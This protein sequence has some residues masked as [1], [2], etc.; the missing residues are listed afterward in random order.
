MTRHY[1]SVR[2]PSPSSLIFIR[3]TYNTNFWEIICCVCLKDEA[4]CEI[5]THVYWVETSNANHYTNGTN[6]RCWTK[7]FQ[8]DFKFS[9]L[10]DFRIS[11]LK[12]IS[13]TLDY[14]AI[15][16]VEASPVRHHGEWFFSFCGES[17]HETASPSQLWKGGFY[18]S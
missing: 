1:L 14:F 2:Y 13:Y 3:F 4:P 8:M 9:L 16:A 10:L 12:G 15:P 7:T 18:V 11:H 17:C 6:K 5:W